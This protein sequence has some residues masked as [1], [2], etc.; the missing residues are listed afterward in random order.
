MR[1]GDVLCW[2]CLGDDLASGDA[3]DILNL[4]R[5]MP[6]DVIGRIGLEF[7]RNYRKSYLLRLCSD[8][9]AI[10]YRFV[11]S[12]YIQRFYKENMTFTKNPDLCVFV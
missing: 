8:L 5:R 4:I 10:R 3:F 2:I 6:R 11:V 1:F 12:R 7:W 9:F